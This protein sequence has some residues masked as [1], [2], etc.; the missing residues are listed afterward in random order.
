VRPFRIWLNVINALLPRDIRRAGRFYIGFIALF[1]LPFGHLAV[2]L[3][4]FVM[5]DKVSTVAEMHVGL[6][7]MKLSGT[8]TNDHHATH[9]FV[10][11]NTT[12]LGDFCCIAVSS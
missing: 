3:T 1:L 7:A 9:Y 6:I 10:S 11:A 2:V 5:A 8:R 12:V 4:F